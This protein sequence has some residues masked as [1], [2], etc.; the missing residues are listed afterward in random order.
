MGLEFS[1]C[2]PPFSSFALLIFQLSIHMHLCTLHILLH[3]L[4]LAAGLQ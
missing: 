2:L 3:F 1:A 4:P